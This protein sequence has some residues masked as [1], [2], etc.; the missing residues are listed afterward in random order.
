[1]AVAVV[2]LADDDADASGGAEGV[3]GVLVVDGLGLAETGVDGAEGVE[4][5]LAGASGTG[6][7][8]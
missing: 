3:L 7:A 1:V 4:G 8:A 6:R 5:G 2:A